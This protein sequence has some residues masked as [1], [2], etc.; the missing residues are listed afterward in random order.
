MITFA[1]NPIPIHVAGLG[2][3]WLIYIKSN[4]MFEDDEACIAL[5]NGGQWRHVTTSM[6]KSWHNATYSIQKSKT[7]EDAS[8][9]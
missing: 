6:I 3:A 8:N 7:N 5:M 2:D 4:G 9:P 1:P